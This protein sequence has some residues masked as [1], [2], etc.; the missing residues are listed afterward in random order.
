MT[1]S[2]REEQP[3]GTDLGPSRFKTIKNPGA[4]C[5]SRSTKSHDGDCT[6]K[7]KWQIFRASVVF[8][9]TGAPNIFDA[10]SHDA[11]PK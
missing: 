9:L 11:L 10:L 7:K 4:L 8:A 1:S 5:T 6:N 3:S 2:E